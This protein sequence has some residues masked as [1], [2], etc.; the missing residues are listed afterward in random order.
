MV[1][2]LESVAR[3]GTAGSHIL[4]FIHAGRDES[5][6]KLVH[7]LR[8]MHRVPH[9]SGSNA[10][11]RPSTSKMITSGFIAVVWSQTHNR[12][13]LPVVPLRSSL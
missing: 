7:Q 8:G 9:G 12:S 1:L 13:G 10:K 2:S 4:H 3:S 11:A 5:K 6:T